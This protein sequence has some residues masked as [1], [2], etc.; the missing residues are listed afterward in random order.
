M[1]GIYA[2]RCRDK[3][4]PTPD[5]IVIGGGHNGLVTAVYLARAGW[6]PLVVEWND[7]AGGAVRSVEI[8]E[9][10]FVHDVYSTNMN[11][12]L[13]SPVYDDSSTN[14]RITVSNS[15]DRKNPSV[16]YFPTAHVFAST[17]TRNA[18]SK[19]FEHT[20]PLMP[21]GGHSFSDDS[22]G[23]S[24]PSCDSTELRYR[25]QRRYG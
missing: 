14:S 17:E 12:F 3:T 1:A 15:L 21:K 24:G 18:R 19:S 9:D 25:P 6:R 10:G 5:V 4:I 20:T 13:D 23:S 22:I 7:E 2:P 8:T 11:L 16:T